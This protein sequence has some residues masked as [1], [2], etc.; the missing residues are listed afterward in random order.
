MEKTMP[1]KRIDEGQGK[2]IDDI[3]KNSLQC[4]CQGESVWFVGREKRL[5]IKQDALKFYDEIGKLDLTPKRRLRTAVQLA[6]DSNKCPVNIFPKVKD[7]WE[8]REPGPGDAQRARELTGVSGMR[9]PFD[10]YVDSAV[11]FL[12]KGGWLD[13]KQEK[14]VAVFAKDAIEAHEDRASDPVAPSAA[15]ERRFSDH[16]ALVAAAVYYGWWH[17]L[18]ELSNPYVIKDIMGVKRQSIRDATDWLIKTASPKEVPELKK[19]NSR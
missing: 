10:K 6:L 16:A 8:L 4:Y 17:E 14:K 5:A 9:W 2:A 1:V 12:V 7:M 13:A 3:L 18:R 15:V 11:S 19:M